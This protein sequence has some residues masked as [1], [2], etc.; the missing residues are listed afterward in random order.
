MM[1]ARRVDGEGIP[2]VGESDR[3]ALRLTPPLLAPCPIHHED[4]HALPACGRADKASPHQEQIVYD[5]QGQADNEA[6][7]DQ[8]IGRPALQPAGA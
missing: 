4:R 7:L 2:A 5:K 6:V 1:S 8:P 3:A